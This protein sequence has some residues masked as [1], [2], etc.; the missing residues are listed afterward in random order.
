MMNNTAALR[1]HNEPSTARN[2][3]IE[4]SLPLVKSIAA[5]LRQAHGLSASFDDLYALGVDGLLQAADRFDSTRGVAFTT[6]AY[7]RI[8]GAILDSLR[9]DPERAR[10]GAPRAA[11]PAG[12][13]ASAQIEAANDNGRA[14]DA[15]ATSTESI[16]WLFA[17]PAAVQV[18]SLDELGSLPDESALHPDEEIERH[19]VAE[20]VTA[21]LSALPETERRVV[22]LHY[23]EELSFAEI[24]ARLGICK[25]WAFRLHNKALKRL[26]EKLAELCD[27]DD[28]EG[29]A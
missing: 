19:R 8:R 27:T 18:T 28:A 25:P 14:G 26:K 17:P 16:A 20:R 2:E 12:S 15:S 6:F 11:V 1:H 9:R 7:Y 10:L 21:A 22:E 23:Y 5:R 3:V 4:R 29:N 24:G 13:R